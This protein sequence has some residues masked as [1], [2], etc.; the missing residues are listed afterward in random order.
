MSFGYRTVRCAAG[1]VPE[2]RGRP[3]GVARV[4]SAGSAG[5]GLELVLHDQGVE[6][7]EHGGLVVGVEVGEVGELVAQEVLGGV[8]RPTVGVS[9][10]EVVDADV[11]G[12]GDPDERFEMTFPTW[13]RRRGQRTGGR[14]SEF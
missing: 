7:F 14:D 8:Q 5:E 1:P 11:E 10:D 3:G 12:L 13:A 9:D 2:R 4:G 6:D